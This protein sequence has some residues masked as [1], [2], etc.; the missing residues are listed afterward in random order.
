MEMTDRI[1]EFLVAEVLGEKAALRGRPLRDDDALVEEGILDSMAI[2]QL[3]SFLEEQFGV[4]VAD[5]EMVPEN[6]G[7]LAR[8]GAFV[9]RKRAQAPAGSDR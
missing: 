2:L 8:L 3:V 6:F 9:E 7:T 4:E 1:R 5:D